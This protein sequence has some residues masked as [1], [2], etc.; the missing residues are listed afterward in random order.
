MKVLKSI[1]EKSGITCLHTLK[2]YLVVQD[3]KTLVKNYKKT[4]KSHRR[5]SDHQ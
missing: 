4:V 3:W 1:S 5:I 2:E